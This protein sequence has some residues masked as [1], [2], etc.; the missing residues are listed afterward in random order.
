MPLLFSYGTLQDDAI[1]FSTFGRLLQGH[2]DELVGFEQSLA[3]IDD[4]E[5]VATSG[6]SHYANVISNGRIDSRVP[7]TVFEV[8]D[9]ELAAADAYEEPAGYKR[10]TTVLASGKEA[11]VYMNAAA[12]L[13]AP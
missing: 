9:A 5:E 8:T 11:W 1:Q 12:S 10:L 3:R 6:K 7:G 2:R 4:P 13:E